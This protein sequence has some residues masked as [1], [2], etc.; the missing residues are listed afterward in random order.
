MTRSTSPT[1]EGGSSRAPARPG[2]RRAIAAG[3]ALAGA[4]AVHAAPEGVD[5]RA[6]VVV[7]LRGAVDGLSVV[8]PHGDPEYT[9]VRREIA[10]A[11]PGAEGGA[12]PLDASFGLHPAL[13]ALS[14][15]WASGRLAFV[16]ASGSPDPTRSHFDAQDFMESATPGRRTTPDGWLNRL[17]AEL[18]PPDGAGVRGISVGPTMPRLL[19]G[20]A[21][22]ASLPGGAAANRRAAVPAGPVGEALDRLYSGDPHASAAWAALRESSAMIAAADDLPAMDAA[23]APGALPFAALPAE[24]MRLGRLLAR[25]PSIRA[26]SFSLGGWDTHVNQGGARGQ[27]AN[28]LQALAN[29]LDA[30]ARG[31][32]PRFDDTV[33]LVM[34][35]FGRTVA[36]N[37]TQGTDHGH[38]NAMWLLGGR[39]RGA[40]VH[41]R[42]PGLETAALH[43]GRDLAITT[44][45]RQVIA[46]VLERH[47]RLDDA[48]I[49]RVLPLGAGR[50]DR[51]DALLG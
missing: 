20:A 22:V 11:P 31:L 3:L 34:S 18:G 2:R 42:W 45:F 9:R 16:H 17:L 47:L 50:G 38:G 46:Q 32:G 44:D 35:E 37:G 41:G 30:L 8:V 19:V 25:E 33:V 14:P 39:V 43:D 7:M 13:S 26:A 40:R 23:V 27:L 51:V 1:P 29:G 48:R 49:A 36:Q 10:I 24:A 15:H 21:Q 12:L 6:L 4:P 5:R 28:R